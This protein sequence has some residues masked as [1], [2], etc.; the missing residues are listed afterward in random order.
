M[1]N[2][3]EAKLHELRAK[4][5]RELV[6]LISNRIDR[7]LAFVRVLESDGHTRWASTEQFLANA[8][9]AL[10]EATAWMT[11]LNGVSDPERRQLA[12]RLTELRDAVDRSHASEVR[13]QAAC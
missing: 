10:S 2:S 9:K 1:R 12:T 4:T 13:M 8:E 11:L 5:N 6:S 3:A 7:G